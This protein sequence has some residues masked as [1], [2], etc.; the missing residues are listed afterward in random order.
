MDYR[1]KEKGGRALRI[2]PVGKFSDGARL[3]E[4]ERRMENGE[5]RVEMLLFYKIILYCIHN[6]LC[7]FFHTHLLKDP[8]TISTHSLIRNE[9]FV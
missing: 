5:Q 3:R 8:G 6:K 2:C 1:V 4:G 9:N 7:I